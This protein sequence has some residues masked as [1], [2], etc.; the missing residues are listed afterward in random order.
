M[1]LTPE[2]QKRSLEA[3]NGWAE[4]LGDKLLDKGCPFMPEA[5]T[6]D[7]KMVYESTEMLTG[8]SV[9]SAET[10]D[11]ALGYAK[12]NPVFSMPGVEVHVFEEAP[13]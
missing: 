7:G 2:E 5:K 13:M 1:E 4:M 11:E 3:W 9:I 8:Y 12:S 6:T 10:M